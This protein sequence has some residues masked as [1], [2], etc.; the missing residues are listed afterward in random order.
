[1]QILIKKQLQRKLIPLNK[2]KMSMKVVSRY[3]KPIIILKKN[4]RLQSFKVVSLLK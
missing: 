2:M 1:M 4:D 3:G